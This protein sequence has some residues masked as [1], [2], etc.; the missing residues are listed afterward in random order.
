VY[1][2][3]KRE[4]W[5]EPEYSTFIDK[6]NIY[7]YNV[8]R[9]EN[10]YHIYSVEMITQEMIEIKRAIKQIPLCCDDMNYLVY[11]FLYKDD[12]FN[13]NMVFKMVDYES[14]REHSDMETES[15]AESVMDLESE[16]NEV[17]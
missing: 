1:Q 16:V 12:Y 9:L 13:D 6:K 4:I 2:Q 14:L 10:L 7:K 17:D 3:Y 11:S 15:S 8:A 5:V